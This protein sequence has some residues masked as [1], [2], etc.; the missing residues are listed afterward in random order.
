MLRLSTQL[1][2]DPGTSLSRGLTLNGVTWLVF[3]L[4]EPGQAE[5]ALATSIPPFTNDFG[6]PAH[7]QL[8]QR[9]NKRLEADS[10]NI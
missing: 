7:G 6:T 1:I 4:H 3:G 2:I 10:R 8:D 5:A 9:L